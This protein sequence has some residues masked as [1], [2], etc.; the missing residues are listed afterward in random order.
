MT[1]VLTPITGSFRGELPQD[2]KAG[3]RYDPDCISELLQSTII[4]SKIFRRFK[5]ETRKNSEFYRLMHKE[6]GGSDKRPHVN[7]LHSAYI[8]GFFGNVALDT[9]RLAVYHEMPHIDSTEPGFAAVFGLVRNSSFEK[10]GTILVKAS[11]DS[12]DN[13]SIIQEDGQRE[14]MESAKNRME[15]RAE[16]EV[17]WAQRRIDFAKVYHGSCTIQS[18]HTILQ[19]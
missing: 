8:S 13:L 17:I 7:D 16:V 10:S 12:Y 3:T 6:R 2:S 14:G 19:Q 18:H 5:K 11:A 4:E 15:G 9:S 1:R